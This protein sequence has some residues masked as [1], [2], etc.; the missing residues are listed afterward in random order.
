MIAMQGLAPRSATAMEAWGVA[1]E[2]LRPTG[3]EWRGD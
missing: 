3:K 2:E 1:R